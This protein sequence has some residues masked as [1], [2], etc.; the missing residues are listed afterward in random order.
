MVLTN[1]SRQ[2]GPVRV[3]RAGRDDDA[4]GLEPERLVHRDRVVAPH[5]DRRAQLPPEVVK[6]VR[7][8]VV[9]I[10]Q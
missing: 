5:L 10:D 7:D 6:V 1:N 2:A 3:A 9:I 4:L 8:A